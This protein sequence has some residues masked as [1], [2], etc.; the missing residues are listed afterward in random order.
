MGVSHTVSDPGIR[1]RSAGVR[2][3]PS[4][5]VKAKRPPTGSAEETSRR[6]VVLSRK[7]SS[8][9]SRRTTSNRPGG[10]GGTRPTEKAAPEPVLRGSLPGQGDGAGARV[11][12]HVGAA[13]LAGDEQPGAAR[14]AAEVEQGRPG[15]HARVTGEGADLTGGHEA[16]LTDELP[17][18]E[19]SRTRPPQ[20]VVERRA[21]SRAHGGP[22]ARAGEAAVL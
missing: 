1:S 9:S 18:S 14:A 22:C 21:Q 2:G 15:A 19:G 4:S 5:T 3:R 20:L 13:E 10:S 11:H 6:R 16:L 7:A 8:V 17:R 12:P